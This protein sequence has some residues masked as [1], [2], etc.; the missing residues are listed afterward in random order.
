MEWID[1]QTARVV[2]PEGVENDSLQDKYLSISG[3]SEM[4]CNGLFEVLHSGPKELEIHRPT[5]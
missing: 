2:L 1:Q 3:A 5:D 4:S